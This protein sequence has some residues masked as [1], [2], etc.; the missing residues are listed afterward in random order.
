[1]P[2]VSTSW[3][4]SKAVRTG[5]SKCSP[6]YKTESSPCRIGSSRS[7][8]RIGMAAELGEEFKTVATA[9]RLQLCCAPATPQPLAAR[10]AKHEGDNRRGHDW[11][12]C[13]GCRSDP[14]GW[15]APSA[16]CCVAPL[17]PP[18]L[19]AKA[20]LLIILTCP[21]TGRHETNSFCM[22]IPSLNLSASVPLPA[23]GV[24][25]TSRGRP[26]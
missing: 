24:S 5:H 9:P 12:G 17:C 21:S 26:C 19:H 18:H 11:N 15:L 22:S 20:G 1:M 3:H 10:K 8:L 23:A 13:R 6:T 16:A 7:R 2:A 4:S 25:R 14:R